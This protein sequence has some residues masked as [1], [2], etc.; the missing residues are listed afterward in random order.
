NLAKPLDITGS[1]REWPSSAK[2][3]RAAKAAGAWCDIEKPFWQD[4]PLWLASGL[5]DSVGI[6]QNHMQIAGMMDNEAWGRARDREKY[7][8]PHGNG[9]YTQDLYYRILNCGFRLPP[10]AGGASGVL[11]NPVGYNRVYVQCDAPLAWEKWWAGLKAGRAFVSNGPLLRV[12][13]EGQWP[14]HVL[15][16]AAPLTVTLAG[17][18]D[19]R[20]AIKS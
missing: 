16:S 20:D 7:P 5:V 17:K 10:S 2:F 4:V 1:Q 8:G 12:K 13:A 19:S 11:Q 18:L 6:C 14:G 9:F 15:K 3:L